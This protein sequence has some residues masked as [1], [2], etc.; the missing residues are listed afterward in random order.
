MQQERIKGRRFGFIAGASGIGK[1]YGVGSIL[2][3]FCGARTFVTGD[4]CREF[5]TSD[6]NSGNLAPDDM[7]FNA[8]LEDFQKHCQW[9]YFVDAPRSIKQVDMIMNMFA[10]KDR[11]AQVH[12]IYVE[13]SWES[14]EKRLKDRANRQHR[15]D[16]A[17]PEVI[18]RRLNT[19]FCEGGIRDT[20][21]PYLEERTR[22]HH[23][24]GNQDLEKIRERTHYRLCPLIFPVGQERAR[25]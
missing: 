15:F 13:G 4:W 18:H 20:V 10:Q 2:N 11:L 6:A 1:G 19:F 5:M 24:D 3:E 23:I 22:I 16:D 14:C 25:V 21:I 8:I 12:T 9:H 7:I 17:E